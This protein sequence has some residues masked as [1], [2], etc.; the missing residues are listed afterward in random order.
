MTETDRMRSHP[1]ALFTLV[2]AFALGGCD[3]ASE[4]DVDA[5]AQDEPAPAAQDEPA[6]AASKARA[7]QTAPKTDGDATV[8]AGSTVSAAPEPKEPLR[9]DMT[10]GGEAQTAEK[11]EQWMDEQGVRVAEGSEDAAATGANADAAVTAGSTE[12]TTKAQSD[13]QD[14][15]R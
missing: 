1:L 3:R 12:T 11:F 14:T 10:Q 13:T 2:C 4:A 7:P 15:R 8:T 6:A 5:E 9:F